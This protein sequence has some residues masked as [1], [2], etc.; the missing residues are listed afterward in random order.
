MGCRQFTKP[1][2]KGNLPVCIK[3]LPPKKDDLVLDQ[4]FAD[5]ADSV[6]TKGSTQVNPNK[7]R[8]DTSCKGFNFK[9]LRSKSHVNI[10]L[11]RR[12]VS[13]ER[14]STAEWK[15]PLNSGVEK[16]S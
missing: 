15:Q 4:S 9:V 1:S 16:G 11:A 7:L 12:I 14:L 3:I 5:I 6:V 10:F 2:R 13:G 8:S